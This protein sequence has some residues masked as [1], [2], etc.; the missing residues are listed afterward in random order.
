MRRFLLALA[1]CIPTAAAATTCRDMTF[2][3]AP[4]TVC[5]VQA[6]EDLRLFLNGP[7][8]ILG[9]FSAVN[10]LLAPQ[11]KRLGFAMNAGMYHEDRSPVG[12]YVEDGQ[13]K[14][15]LVTRDGPGNF[16]LLPNGVFC[17]GADGGFGV[18]ESRRF[19]DTTPACRFASQSGPMLVIDGDLHPRLIPDSPSRY[20][21]NG[22]GVSADGRRAVF[23]I[24]GRAVNFHSFARLFRDGLELPNA[25]YFDGSI[26]RLHAPDL[27]RNDFGFAMGPIIGTVVPQ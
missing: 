26:S 25:L 4:Y 6:G 27:G 8:G 21:R 9:S 15:R 5:E 3:D 1:L 24:S 11:G 16:G 18:I 2:E 12:L 10:A 23:A 20:I 19:R 7:D 22:V 14:A 17:V 13:E